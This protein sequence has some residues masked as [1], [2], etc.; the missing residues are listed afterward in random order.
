M[1][2]SQGYQIYLLSRCHFWLFFY[3]SP[4]LPK[5][6][7]FTTEL[8]GGILLVYQLLKDF[9]TV[10]TILAAKGALA[11][12]KIRFCCVQHFVCFLPLRR[13]VRKQ[14]SAT[15]NKKQISLLFTNMGS[16]HTFHLI[17]RGASLSRNGHVSH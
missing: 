2:S 16:T 8:I 1:E 9:I 5:I 10:K 13:G 11:F 12:G 15:F 3:V 14:I 6:K 4:C 17:F 7:L